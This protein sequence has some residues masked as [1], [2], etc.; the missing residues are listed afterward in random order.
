MSEEIKEHTKEISYK[1]DKKAQPQFGVSMIRDMSILLS[2]DVKV[3]MDGSTKLGTFMFFRKQIIPSKGSA[4]RT[5]QLGGINHEL[6]LEV[7]V[8]FA[9]ILP[10]LVYMKEHIKDMQDANWMN[11]ALGP[12]ELK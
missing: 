8:P 1:G 7:K 12:I 6:F 10:L 3:F 11:G 5:I 9:A 4:E 2:D